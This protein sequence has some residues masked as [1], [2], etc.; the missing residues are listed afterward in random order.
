MIGR[1]RSGGLRGGNVGKQWSERFASHGAPGSEIDRRAHSLLRLARRQSQDV[2]KQGASVASAEL[3]GN[4]AFAEFGNQAMI[5]DGKPA[6][7]RL[8]TA[9][10]LEEFFAIERGQ[11]E[12]RQFVDCVRQLAQNGRVALEHT[13]DSTRKIKSLTSKIHQ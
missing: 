3:A 11:V 4:A 2:A 10:Q 6:P 12:R 5:D 1:D 7:L 9:E 13:Y 8:Q